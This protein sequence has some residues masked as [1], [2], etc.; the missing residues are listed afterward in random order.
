MSELPQERQAG[1][2]IT[3]EMIEAGVRVYDCW[4]PDHIFDEVGGLPIMQSVSW[5]QMFLGQ[6]LPSQ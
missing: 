1:V 3:P 5:W 6:C 4:E 2:D